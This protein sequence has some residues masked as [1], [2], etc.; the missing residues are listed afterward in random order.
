[1]IISSDV[2]GFLSLL[3]VR[4]RVFEVS[5]WGTTAE[6]RRCLEPIIF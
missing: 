2:D 3:P 5:S 6:G 1:M 4:C